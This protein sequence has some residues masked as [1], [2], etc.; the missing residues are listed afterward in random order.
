MVVLID[1][2]MVM[3]I[4]F[5]FTFSYNDGYAAVAVLRCQGDANTMLT[6]V[7]C[8]YK[9]NVGD[10]DRPTAASHCAAK[11]PERVLH[12]KLLSLTLC[13]PPLPKPL[14]LAKFK[15]TKRGLC[16]P[17]YGRCSFVLAGCYPPLLDPTQP[18]GRCLT[19]AQVNLW[20]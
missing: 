14:Q 1:F 9:T 16:S 19:Q 7:R 17:F 11:S 12:L 6:A 10:V 5:G 8:K 18:L 20:G 2:E 15:M 13:L 3:L 4:D